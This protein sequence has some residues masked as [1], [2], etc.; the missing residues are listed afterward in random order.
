M[1]SPA[2]RSQEAQAIERARLGAQAQAAQAEQL[3]ASQVS[4]K[5]EV[6]KTHMDPLTLLRTYDKDRMHITEE[7][8]RYLQ[9]IE[10]NPQTFR[11]RP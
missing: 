7:Q 11:G 3:R 4:T 10:S 8:R 5:F 2:Q 6:D 9:Q 1:K